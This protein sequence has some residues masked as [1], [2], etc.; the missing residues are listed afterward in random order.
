MNVP[1][2]VGPKVTVPPKKK[3]KKK[4]KK[5]T[6]LKL[7]IKKSHALLGPEFHP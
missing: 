6:H 1:G 3:K 5:K 4:R 7:F 2:N